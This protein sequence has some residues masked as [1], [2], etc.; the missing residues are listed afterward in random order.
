[1]AQ[2]AKRIGLT[3]TAVGLNGQVTSG[4]G[5][6]TTVRRE[7]NYHNIWF[8]LIAEP[9]ADG[10]NANGNWALWLKKDAAAGDALFTDANI[11][12]ETFNQRIIACG[13]WAGA[14]E[15]PFNFSSQLK[16]SRN[17]LAGE[18]IRLSIH[19][20]GITGGNVRLRSMLCAGETGK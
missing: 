9:E 15:S 1:M 14:N 4:F 17:L 2:E 3:S 13:V 18:E 12:A 8:G 5:P 16:S 6:S 10:A 11:Q 20:D 19:V 7:V